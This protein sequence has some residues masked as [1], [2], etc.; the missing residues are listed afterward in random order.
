[1]LVKHSWNKPTGRFHARLNN[2]S[3]GP[4]IICNQSYLSVHGDSQA[5]D[6]ACLTFN[7]KLAVYYNFLTSGRFP[8]LAAA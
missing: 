8:D 2:A 7:S 3:A 5:L 4:G 6:A 1:M